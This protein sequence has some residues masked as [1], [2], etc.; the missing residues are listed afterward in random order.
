M[1]LISYAQNFED[2]MLWRALKG[3]EKGFYIDIGAMSPDTD[4]VTKLF[5][6]A[7]WRGINFEPQPQFLTTLTAERPR[8]INLGIAISDHTGEAEF[9]SVEKT[10]LSTLDPEAA[11]RALNSGRSV[12]TIRVPVTTIAESWDRYVPPEQPVHFL[13]IDVEGCEE[14]VIRGADWRRHR[15]WIVVAEATVPGSSLQSHHSWEPVLLSQGYRLVWFDGLNRFYLAD[16]HAELAEA[17]EAP[18]NV[19]DGFRRAAEVALETRLHAA[20]ARLSQISELTNWVTGLT[21]AINELNE[22]LSEVHAAIAEMR[23]LLEEERTQRQALQAELIQLQSA[24]ERTE[25]DA[26]PIWTRL[27]FYR[28]GKPRK[29]LRRALFHTSG[30]PRGIFRKWVLHSNGRPRRAFRQWISSPD[31][32]NLRAGIKVP[33]IADTLSPEAARVALRIAASHQKSRTLVSE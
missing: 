31:Y 24:Y 14:Q 30:K 1:T 13:K 19:F 16:E 20:K 5:Y 21:V 10:G 8:D 17:F 22:N 7:S 26:K 28:S 11:R 6:D 9:Q 33:R 4:S 18:P 32:Q 29:L 15:P 2:V 12:R 25:R 27:L 3:I 23:P